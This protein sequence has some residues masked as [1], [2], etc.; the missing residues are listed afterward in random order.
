MGMVA[1]CLNVSKR[2]PSA[3]ER[4]LETTPTRVIGEAG[5]TNSADGQDIGDFSRGCLQ[6]TQDLAVSNRGR[7]GRYHVLPTERGIE[8]GFPF[9]RCRFKSVGHPA[10]RV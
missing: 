5:R 6:D 2:D 10:S 9:Q 1:L 7:T 4:H 8:T 3:N